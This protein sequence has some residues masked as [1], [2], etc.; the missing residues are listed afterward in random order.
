[1][2]IE[3][4]KRDKTSHV[5]LWVSFSLW[6]ASLQHVIHLFKKWRKLRMWPKPP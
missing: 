1:M 5:A 2:K 6:I 3:E 4:T